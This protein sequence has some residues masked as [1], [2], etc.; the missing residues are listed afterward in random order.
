M[1]VLGAQSLQMPSP[2]VVDDIYFLK[3]AAI[4]K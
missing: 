3:L 2:N 1:S 4:S